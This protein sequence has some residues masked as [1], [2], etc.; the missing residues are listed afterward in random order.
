MGTVARN[1]E[2]G[3]RSL[4]ANI[5]LPMPLKRVKR[6]VGTDGVVSVNGSMFN[7]PQFAGQWIYVYFDGITDAPC[8][9]EPIRTLFDLLAKGHNSLSEIE[10]ELKA[11]SSAY[12]ALPG[13]QV[14]FLHRM[15]GIPVEGCLPGA[16]P[17][18]AVR[19]L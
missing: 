12:P 6:L 3:V 9:F 8:R 4:E 13:Q 7:V 17:S 2:S 19:S 11:S 1:R 5:G 15:L 14:A 18:S 16:D 10:A